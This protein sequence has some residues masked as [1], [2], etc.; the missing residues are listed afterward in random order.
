MTTD[1]RAGI[2]TGEMIVVHR[3]FRRESRLLAELIAAVGPG[4]RAR[5]GVLVAH[6]RDYVSAVHIHHS[7][8][9]E[10]LWPKLL[11]RLDQDADV[12]LRMEAGHE[13]I[14]T[15][16]DRVASAADAWEA[17]PGE[18]ER[19]ALVAALVDQRAILVEHLDDEEA[20]LLPLAAQH[21]TLAEWA[22]QGEH[23][24]THTPKSKLLLFLGMALEEA[25]PA[26]RDKMLGGMP[27]PARVLW[28]SIGRAQYARYVRKVRG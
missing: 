19:D 9:D 16:L 20:A 10:L 11:T 15:S 1:T 26:E 21:L 22:A 28:Y 5:A 7:G 27:L 12:V 24:A 13:R 18:D 23:F 14:S 6:L 17:A 4:D 3:L 8:E 2:D 25:T